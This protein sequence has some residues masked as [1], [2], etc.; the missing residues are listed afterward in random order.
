MG[1]FVACSAR[2]SVDTQ[3]QT[4][5]QNDY[6]NPRCACAPRVNQKHCTGVA[7]IEAEEAVASPVFADV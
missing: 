7:S 1:R 4:D 5:R 3:T 6:S 2:I